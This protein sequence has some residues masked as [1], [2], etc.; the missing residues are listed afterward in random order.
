MVAQVMFEYIVTGGIR[1]DFGAPMFLVDLR[2]FVFKNKQNPL[3]KGKYKDLK[4]GIMLS[5]ICPWF[6]HMLSH[7]TIKLLCFSFKYFQNFANQS[8]P[9]AVWQALINS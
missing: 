9:Q 6:R 4:M 8:R 5:F 1:Y 2:L 7:A 3:Q